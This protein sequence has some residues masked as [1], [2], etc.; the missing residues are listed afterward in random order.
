MKR[1][2]LFKKKEKRM[3]LPFLTF[4]SFISLLEA[5][6]LFAKN[7]KRKNK[8]ISF[9]SAKNKYSIDY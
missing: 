9:M 3:L 2:M 1:K 8:N 7:K 6:L 5:R 4:F